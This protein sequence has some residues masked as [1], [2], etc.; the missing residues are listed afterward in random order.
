[1]PRSSRILTSSRSRMARFM[2]SP[3]VQRPACSEAMAWMS[4]SA[5]ARK[6]GGRVCAEPHGE[7]V[8]RGV[9]ARRST[10][11]SWSACVGGH[12]QGAAAA[13]CG[14]RR[15]CHHRVGCDRFGLALPSSPVPFPS[16][17][18][19]LS[20]PIP[21]QVEPSSSATGSNTPATPLPL[22]FAL[23]EAPP[24]PP[25][26]SPPF[27][28]PIPVVSWPESPLPRLVTIEVCRSSEP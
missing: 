15:V 16:L 2:A 6:E 27:S 18:P 21:D 5:P 25:P 9:E 10:G 24:P 4:T 14:R 12:G 26:P 7:L 22:R 8:G 17:S 28:L 20:S 11:T 23:R 1:M 19:F 3:V 13:A